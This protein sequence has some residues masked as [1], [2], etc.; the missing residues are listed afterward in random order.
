M[1]NIINL[2]KCKTI[3]AVWMRMYRHCRHHGGFQ[4]YCAHHSH[5]DYGV[6]REQYCQYD[7]C[8]LLAGLDRHGDGRENMR[9]E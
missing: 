7:Y 4:S 2:S 8:P 6:A 3:T 1:Q 5:P 9:C